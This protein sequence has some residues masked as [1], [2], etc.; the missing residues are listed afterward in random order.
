[1]LTEIESNLLV[2]RQLRLVG[3]YGARTRTDMP[4]LLA[5]VADG[6]VKLGQT[7]SRRVGLDEVADVYAALDRGEI[8]GRAVVRI[9]G[10]EGR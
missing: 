7:I 10:T 9:N 3:S 8:V 1:V 6:R 2:R 4:D 5:L